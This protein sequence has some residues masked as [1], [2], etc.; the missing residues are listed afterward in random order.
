LSIFHCPLKET[1]ELVIKI[2]NKTKN[3]KKNW[4]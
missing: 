2:F 4:S 1:S 3:K